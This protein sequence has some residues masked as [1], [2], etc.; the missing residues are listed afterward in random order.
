MMPLP[1]LSICVPSRNRQAYFQQTIIGLLQ[2]RNAD[3]EFVFADNSDD[4]R[5][6]RNFLAPYG[7]D[8]LVRF[9]PS[10]DRVLSM[11]ENWE[12]TI[13]ASTGTWI[14]FIGDDDYV[15]PAVSKFI[16]KIQSSRPNVEA[17]DWK[18]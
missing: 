2:N 12:R 7:Q 15:D 11:Q 1:L 9:L 3:T 17:I 13:K 6:M 5:I 10:E 8:P 16:A 14:S 4:G 18:N